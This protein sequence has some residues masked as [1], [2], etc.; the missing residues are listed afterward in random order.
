MRNCSRNSQ[1][2][3]RFDGKRVRISETRHSPRLTDSLLSCPC[4]EEG[5]AEEQVEGGNE[6]RTSYVTL[7]N[8]PRTRV[9]RAN[10]RARARA[11]LRDRRVAAF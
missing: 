10:R 8:K 3:S 9:Q 1:T 7:F 2:V 4:V 11:R 5:W 6:A